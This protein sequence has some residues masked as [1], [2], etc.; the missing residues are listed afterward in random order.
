MVKI[1]GMMIDE[2]AE[3]LKE[4]NIKLEVSKSAKDLIIKTGTDSNYG[5][6]PLRRV[7]QRMLEDK[8]AEEMLERKYKTRGYCKSKS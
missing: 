8:L 4:Q 7:I 3:K 2:V 6:R 5:A 1:A